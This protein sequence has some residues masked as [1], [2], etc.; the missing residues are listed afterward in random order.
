[1][2]LLPRKYIDIIYNF[3]YLSFWYLPHMHARVHTTHSNDIES[4]SRGEH[5]HLLPFLAYFIFLRLW[6]EKILNLI[7]YCKGKRKFW[8]RWDG[9][10]NKCAICKRDFVGIFYLHFFDLKKFT[11]AK[12]FHSIWLIIGLWHN[13]NG[14]RVKLI[15]AL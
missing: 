10:V 5:S 15:K 14:I 1:M 2:L 7:D 12:E 4:F 9:K 8:T 13:F 6:V 11:D 3:T